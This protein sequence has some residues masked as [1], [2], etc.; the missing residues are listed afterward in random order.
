MFLSSLSKTSAE[1]GM[2]NAAMDLAEALGETQKTLI[3]NI[4][5]LY[6]VPC[7]RISDVLPLSTSTL[8]LTGF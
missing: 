6:E 1:L 4:F 2:Q 8:H 7:T 5:L 3:K